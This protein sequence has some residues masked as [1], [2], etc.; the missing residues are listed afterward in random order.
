MGN[1]EGRAQH[2]QQQRQQLLRVTYTCDDPRCNC[3][4]AIQCTDS[5]AI[6]MLVV[7]CPSCLG[8]THIKNVVS[9]F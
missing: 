2:Q 6:C 7:S 5:I 3:D 8:R 1:S 4:T 9:F